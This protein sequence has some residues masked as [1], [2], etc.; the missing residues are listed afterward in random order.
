M[1]A[2]FALGPLCSVLPE[3]TAFVNV[4][5][6]L[7]MV[8]GGSVVSAH[9]ATDRPAPQPKTRSGF[10]FSFAFGGCTVLFVK[11]SPVLCSA[12]WV[13]DS[14]P[15]IAETAAALKLTPLP[16]KVLPCCTALVDAVVM[17]CSESP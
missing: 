13:V 6:T 11:R 3:T 8:G 16:S 1:P 12:T 4:D 15:P 10:A 2:P 14:P 17:L 5:T 9:S 7:G